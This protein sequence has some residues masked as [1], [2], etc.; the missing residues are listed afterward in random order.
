M[1]YGGAGSFVLQAVSRITK[2]TENLKSLRSAASAGRA[3]CLGARAGPH[4]R[5]ASRDVACEINSSCWLTGSWLPDLGY[6]IANRNIRSMTPLRARP[7]SL[8]VEARG[9]TPVGVFL[10]D[11]ATERPLPY[12]HHQGKW[13]NC[14]VSTGCPFDQELK[15]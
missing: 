9:T 15:S 11:N 7:F 4:L 10:N 1:E 5:K 6:W 3:T 13:S 8:K 12:T 2:R 14:E